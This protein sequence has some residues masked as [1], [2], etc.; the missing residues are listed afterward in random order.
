MYTKFSLSGYDF[1]HPIRCGLLVLLA[2]LIGVGGCTHVSYEQSPQWRNG[3]FENP[4]DWPRF[5]TVREFLRWRVTRPISFPEFQPRVV[6]NDGMQLR[7][8]RLRTSVTWIGHATLLVQGGGVSVLTDPIFSQR[9]SGIFSRF[10]A[11]GVAMAKLPPIDVVVISHN[12]RDHLDEPSVKALG[13][14]VHYVVPL[15]LAAWFRQR[16]LT[17]VTELDWWQ[18]TEIKTALGHTAQ[19][20]LVPAQHWSRRGL[21][22][23][24]Q[25]LWGGYVIALAGSHVYF[26]GDTGYPAAFK[27]I[28]RRFANLDYALL[29]IGAYEPRWFMCAQHISPED[30]A[31]AFSDLGARHLI[32]MHYATFRLSDE[33]M[34]EPPLLLQKALGRD[35]D[36]LIELA[37]GE[38][39]WQAVAP[40]FSD[41]R[42]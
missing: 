24:R 2:S 1:S 27:E 13:P 5:P 10:A 18:T 28:G 8:D 33:P 15:G 40:P 16:G 19:V 21:S 7:Q 41:L 42:P 36:H 11:P 3:R 34:D 35:I 14:S 37:I 39:H 12:H 32:P 30:A 17:Q 38:T 20:T 29:P 26:A 22:D 9:I 6:E 23:D 31:R 25:S 4:P